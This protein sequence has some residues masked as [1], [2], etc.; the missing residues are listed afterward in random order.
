MTENFDPFDPTHE[1]TQEQYVRETH[2]NV[3]NILT[4][5]QAIFE[6][7]QPMVGLVESSGLMALFGGKKGKK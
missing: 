3:K 5:I 6:Q 4:L 7:I 1:T 2:E